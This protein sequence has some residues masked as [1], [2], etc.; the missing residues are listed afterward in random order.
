MQPKRAA[1]VSKFLVYYAKMQGKQMA[2]WVFVVCPLS[3]QQLHEGDNRVESDSESFWLWK[4]LHTSDTVCLLLSFFRNRVLPHDYIE[5][6]LCSNAQPVAALGVTKAKSK[7]ER[8]SCCFQ[9]RSAR[10]K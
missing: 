10:N 9:A 1:R 7:N 2:G 8:L 5:M 3:W 4:R 6:E